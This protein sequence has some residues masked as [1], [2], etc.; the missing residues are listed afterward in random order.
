MSP[1]GKFDKE[2]NLMFDLLIF[3]LQIMEIRSTFITEF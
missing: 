2:N 1:Y 3:T